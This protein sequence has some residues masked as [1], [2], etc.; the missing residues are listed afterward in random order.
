M[1]QG[2]YN[3]L[4]FT[5]LT[6]TH[7][8][9][10][11]NK[12]ILIKMKKYIL[13]FLA[14]SISLS[15]M[16]QVLKYSTGN[17]DQDSLGNHRVVVNLDKD[18][19]A[20]MVNIPWRRKDM[21]PEEKEVIII[22][23]S[24]GKRI[25][26]IIR[27]NVTREYGEFIFEP[28]DG[29]GEYYFYYLPYFDHGR[30][31]Y[32]TVEYYKPED[33]AD[34]AWKKRTSNMSLVNAVAVEMQ[35]INEFHSFYPMEVIATADEVYDFLQKHGDK[36]YLLFPEDRYHPIKMWTD[37]PYRWIKDDL[38]SVLEDE[39][40][41]GEYYAFQ[42]GLYA[43]DED[44]E[45]INILFS[46][47][48]S[49]VSSIPSSAFSCFNKYGRD[50]TL[51]PLVKKVYVEKGKV[52]PL[53]MGVMI[54]EDAKPGIYKADIKI[55]PNV[56]ENQSIRL[57]LE[58]KEGLI[59]AHGDDNPYSHSRLRWLDSD[60]ASDNDVIPPY[61][62]MKVDN[63]VIKLLGRDLVLGPDGLP[64]QVKGFFSEE[65][66]GIE[67]EFRPLLSD[68]MK[69]EITDSEG[70][71]IKPDDSSLS[72]L[73]MDEGLVSWKA[74]SRI[75][76]FDLKVK[77][78]IEFD[79]FMEYKVE[80][81]AKEKISIKDISFIIPLDKEVGKYMLGLGRKGGF[82]PDEFDYKWDP[83]F[84]NDGPWIGDVN[85][86]LQSSFRDENYE[87]PLNTNFY[88]QKPLNM[89]TSWYNEGKGGIRLERSDGSYNIIAYTG[90]RTIEKGEVLNFNIQFLIT[91]FRSI[92]TKSHW[93]NR[94]YH[95]YEPVDSILA[96]GGNT[97][98]VH[99]ATEINPYI[100]YPFM[101]PE[102]MK[103]YID[104]AH[105]KDARVKIY[106][107]VR[108]LSNICP[109]IWALK[110][111][112]DEILSYGP[113]GGYSWLQEHLDG[114]Y[115]P[116][117]FVPDIRDAA[118][119]NSGVSRW[120]NYYLE[121][122]NWLAKNVGID[123]LYIDDVAFDRSIMKRVRKILLRENPDALIDLHSANQFN[124]RDGFANS[125][126]LYMEHFAYIDR[127]WFGE[128]FDY[129]A[130]PEYWLTEVSGVPFGLMGE[131]LQDGGNPWRGMIYGMTSRAP[132]SGDPSPIWKLWDEFGIQDSQMTGYWID[133][134]P[135]K[136]GR[137]DVL[138]TVYEKNGSALIALASWAD[139]PARI[140]L[141]IDWEALGLDPAKV[142]MVAP[143]VKDFQEETEFTVG[144]SFQVPA[145]KG[146]LI[147]VN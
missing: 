39:V 106:Y 138:A 21:N 3:S 87:R 125:A 5:L 44:I 61:I 127:L 76:K 12:I 1:V 50:W 98:N 4:I 9:L 67:K 47:L 53:W 117:W 36:D 38:K 13:L 65:M 86:G 35:S 25:T 18:A 84:N 80:L 114:N 43:K 6:E 112:G 120:H 129:D 111:L 119:I 57:E 96:Y 20:A 54:P 14:M 29:K 123:G 56:M 64:W 116:A 92:D 105:S 89:P 133:D 52:Q 77:G 68:R 8:A 100:N 74:G 63:N 42:I 121:G 45:D 46:N 142:K 71:I 118:V 146:Y 141:D 110:S 7:A 103:E 55:M 23:A 31:N 75:D 97:I 51:E 69:F 139:G 24:S 41:Q 22:S 88:Q 11:Q 147:I 122:L 78:Q 115:I 40:R 83:F 113:G 143:S 30:S 66:T 26:N 82:A 104:E 134:C 93:H 108:E 144:E 145:G 28:I 81:K 27:V 140:E 16:P 130:G 94:Y 136:T 135:V 90:A 32:P 34:P 132:W 17:W 102:I 59:P 70:E 33:L 95:R 131:M 49:S 37:L 60:I 124:P 62:P 85:L 73:S 101:T 58:V 48:Q 99:H 91:P 128:Y 126:N 19:D 79:G 109:E 72:F 107:T 15:A 137:P 10:D 2:L